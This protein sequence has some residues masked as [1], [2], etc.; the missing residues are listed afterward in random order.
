MDKNDPLKTPL[1]QIGLSKRAHSLLCNSTVLPNNDEPTVEDLLN[2]RGI[3]WDMWAH[4]ESYG[5]SDL[6][7]AK[8]KEFLRKNRIDREFPPPMPEA[9]TCDVIDDEGQ[10]DLDHDFFEAVENED[11][12]PFLISGE[13]HEAK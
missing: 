13:E 4:Y 3:T 5:I 8:V 1:S 2:V 9:D 7:V 11:A 10:I 12:V 6:V